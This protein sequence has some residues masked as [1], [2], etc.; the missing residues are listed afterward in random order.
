MCGL[1]RRE[2]LDFP[3]LGYAFL[4]KH[5]RCGYASEAGAAVL[6]DT[7]SRYFSNDP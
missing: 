2:T 3:D 7:P 4:A 6:D 1:I 5:H